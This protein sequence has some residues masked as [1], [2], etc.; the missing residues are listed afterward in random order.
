MNIDVTS[1]IVSTIQTR[2]CF[3]NVYSKPKFGGGQDNKRQGDRGDRD[4]DYDRGNKNDR[5]DRNNN[6]RNDRD[7]KP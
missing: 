6:R 5:G 4:R 2:K 3:P 7:R 1:N